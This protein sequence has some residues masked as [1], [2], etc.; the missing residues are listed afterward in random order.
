[1]REMG[2]LMSVLVLAQRVNNHSLKYSCTHTH[3]APLLWNHNK[4]NSNS[5]RLFFKPNG[6]REN[7]L[8][9]NSILCRFIFRYRFPILTCNM[10]LYLLGRLC[11][12]RSFF[13]CIILSSSRWIKSLLLYQSAKIIERT[14]KK[15]REQRFELHIYERRSMWF[16]FA[17]FALIYFVIINL[18]EQSGME[19]LKWFQLTMNSI[20]TFEM[21]RNV[22]SFWSL[23]WKSE[24]Y[25][26]VWVEETWFLI[27]V[28]V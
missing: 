11:R 18:N 15:Y 20:E 25:A 12:K 10:F 24:K 6:S 17:K 7:L 27:W 8:V 16:L 2:H 4:I 9:L 5:I 23:F 3:T 22:A 14:R 26:F 13:L 28:V 1:M 19:F 21:L